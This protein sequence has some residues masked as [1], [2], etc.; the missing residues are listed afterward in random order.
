MELFLAVLHQLSNKLSL[1]EWL[2]AGEIELPHSR[3]GQ[4]LESLLCLLFVADI[5]G[6]GGVAVGIS[7]NA[8]DTGVG[9][10]H[11][12]NPHL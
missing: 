1:E 11:K 3:F 8:S 6:F 10:A 12:Q 4:E 9:C 7:G 2:A 5:G